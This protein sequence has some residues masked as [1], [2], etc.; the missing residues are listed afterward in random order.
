ME[1]GRDPVLSLLLLLGRLGL[2]LIPPVSFKDR[3]VAWTLVGIK[4]TFI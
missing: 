2:Y 3:F 1:S 4:R